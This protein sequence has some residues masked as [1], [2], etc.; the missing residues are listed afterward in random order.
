MY[1]KCSDL[2]SSINDEAFSQVQF[3]LFAYSFVWL[4][5]L[6]RP[7]DPLLPQ[8]KEDDI[9]ACTKHMCPIRV[10]WHFKNNYV[11]HWRVKLTV[12]NYNYKRNYSNWNVLVQHPGFSQ[13][14]TTY[15]F[16][17]AKLPVGVQ[18]TYPVNPCSRSCNC[19]LQS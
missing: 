17:N 14:A 5:H 19:K 7:G 12:S 1:L 11:D 16:N 8:S 13:N 2:Y 6:T 18:G 4:S 3:P 9:I 15:S 10:H